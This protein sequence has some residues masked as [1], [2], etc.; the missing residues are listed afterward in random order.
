MK[1]TIKEITPQWA[2]QVLVTR[3]PNNRPLSQSF[4]DRLARDICVGAFA[5]THQGIAFDENG[6]LLDGQHRLAA[7]VKANKSVKMVVST[8]IPVKHRLNGVAVNTFEL[9][10]GGRK[11]GVGQML[12]MAGFTNANRQA[13]IVRTIVNACARQS[14]FLSISTAQTHKAL[15]YLKASP[16]EIAKIGNPNQLCS[17]PSG[18]L[19]AFAFWHTIN[20]VASADF[21]TEVTTVTGPPKSPSRALATWIK[22]HS[23]HGGFAQLN[24]MRVA[25]SAIFHQTEGNTLEKIYCSETA[26]DWLLNLNK[27]MAKNLSEIISL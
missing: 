21:L 1:T 2:S 14:S 3:N 13:A 9:I 24:Y 11:R 4:V 12:Q 18:A 20:P 25:A 10:D 17:P 8:G 23:I 22:R 7:I 6:D 16:D 15:H 26:L 5:V 19:A 27:P